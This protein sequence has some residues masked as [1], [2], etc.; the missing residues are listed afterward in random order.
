MGDQRLRL[1]VTSLKNDEAYRGWIR[2]PSENLAEPLKRL[3]SVV[4]L[5]CADK[6]ILAILRGDVSHEG[7]ATMA[8]DWDSRTRLGVKKDQQA[9]VYLSNVGLPLRFWFYWNHPDLPG[10][11]ASRLAIVS[12]A[13]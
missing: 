7:R 1:T 5:R 10:R 4:R 13:L 12:L 3:N 11:F 8:M 9:D 2:I 6:S